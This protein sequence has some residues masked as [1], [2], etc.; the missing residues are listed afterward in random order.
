MTEAQAPARHLRFTWRGEFSN[1]SLNVLHAE[2]FKH[3]VLDYD[4]LAQVRGHSLGW[5]CMSTS[6]T[7][8]C[9]ACTSTPAAFAQ[10]SPA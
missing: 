2:A 10:P 6:T 3:A 9:A 5:G 8:G 4:W 7:K 1:H